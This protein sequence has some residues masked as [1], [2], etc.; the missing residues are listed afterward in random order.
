MLMKLFQH[1]IS[2]EGNTA[3]F[4]ASSHAIMAISSVYVTDLPLDE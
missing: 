4:S 2:S 1:L 3:W